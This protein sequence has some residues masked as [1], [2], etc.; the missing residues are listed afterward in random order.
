MGFQKGRVNKGFVESAWYTLLANLYGISREILEQRDKKRQT[1][2]R[3][4]ISSLALAVIAALSITT[5]YALLKR[6]EADTER[7]NALDSESSC[8]QQR[9]SGAR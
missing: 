9:P 4:I 1:R 2:R 6:Q 8:R 3:K 5:I 7:D